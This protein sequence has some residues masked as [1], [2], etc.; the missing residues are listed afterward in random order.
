MLKDDDFVALFGGAP[1]Y[2]VTTYLP[3]Q[4]RTAPRVILEHDLAAAGEPKL[5]HV[6]RCQQEIALLNKY[7]WLC[8]W[9][10]ASVMLQRR[11]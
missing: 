7:G 1:M 4:T 2:G 10:A 8:V 5:G 3:L 11:P 6:M 9:P